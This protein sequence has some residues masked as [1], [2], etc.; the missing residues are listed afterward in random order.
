M[1]SHFKVIL[2]ALES[3]VKKEIGDARAAILNNETKAAQYVHDLGHRI[4]AH[5]S[6]IFHQE[7]DK[8]VKE[9]TKVINV[10]EAATG[11]AE[12]KSE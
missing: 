12:G 2:D 11:T 3:K 6:G 8:V 1:A 9:E 7:V 4:E 5:F 10:L